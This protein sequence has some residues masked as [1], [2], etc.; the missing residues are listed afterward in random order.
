MGG[1][2]AVMFYFDG[3][4]LSTQKRVLKKRHIETKKSN[5]IKEVMD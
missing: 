5:E 1:G 4:L 2:V 3:S